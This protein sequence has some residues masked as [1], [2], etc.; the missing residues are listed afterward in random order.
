MIKIK[1][2]TYILMIFLLLISKSAFPDNNMETT[3]IAAIS[4][5]KQVIINKSSLSDIE[6][7]VSRGISNGI[8]NYKIDHYDNSK[9]GWSVVDNSGREVF[10]VIFSLYGNVAKEA[11]YYS[12]L[13]TKN[14]AVEVHK[15]HAQIFEKNLKIIGQD[16]YDINDNCTASSELFRSESYD[17]GRTIVTINCY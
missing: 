12:P 9:I 3:I 14:D 17:T 13:M 1:L 8:K 16:K 6:Y 5:A 15:I 7:I 4:Q 11:K 2:I 10:R